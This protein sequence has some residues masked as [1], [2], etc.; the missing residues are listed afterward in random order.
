MGRLIKTWAS[1]SRACLR[2]DCSIKA[3]CSDLR[4]FA[5]TR[6]GPFV[7]SPA[8]RRREEAR[9]SEWEREGGVLYP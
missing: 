9:H 6:L 3:S 1:W 7:C 4:P 5:P 2:P 8:H